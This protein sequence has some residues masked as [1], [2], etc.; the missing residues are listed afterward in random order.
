MIGTFVN[1]AAIILGGIIGTLISDKL[2]KKFRETVMAGLGLFTLAYGVINFIKTG[3]MLIPL[4]S[5]IVGTILGE[6]WRIE[7]GLDKLGEFLQV[8]TQRLF[9]S[10]SGKNFIKGFVST[11]LLFCIGPMA[12]LGSIQD[13]LT[14]NYQMLAIKAIMDG[15]AAIAFASTL[16]VGVIFSAFMILF[17]QGIISLLSGLISQF[18]NEAMINEMTAVGGIML[19]GIAVSTLLE[20]KKIRVSSFLPALFLA[21]LI[22]WIL[23]LL[24]ISF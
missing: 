24:K 20:L 6:W 10:Q 16:G 19:M 21:P 18:F 14:G 23:S 9:P 5:L 12:I 17:Y 4:G 8:K 7:E 1:F 11:S 15:F 22:V 2:S 3:N 13:G